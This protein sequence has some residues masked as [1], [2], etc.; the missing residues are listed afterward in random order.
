M[1]HKS[2]RDVSVDLNSEKRGD[3]KESLEVKTKRAGEKR[4]D[5]KGRFHR[6]LRADTPQQ[7]HRWKE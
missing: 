6:I 1:K 5:E 4:L 3:P 2:L 7:A